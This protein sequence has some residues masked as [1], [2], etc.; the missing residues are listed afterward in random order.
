M[1]RVRARIAFAVATVVVALSGVV[2]V[3]A[4]RGGQ[5]ATDLASPT[6]GESASQTDEVTVYDSHNAALGAF[7]LCAEAAGFEVAADF[8]G[9]GRRPDRFELILPA[10]EPLADAEVREANDRLERCGMIH[11]EPVRE[12]WTEALPRPT[13]AELDEMLTRVNL[14]VSNGGVP[15]LGDVPPFAVPPRDYGPGVRAQVT[16]AANSVELAAFARQCFAA[17]EASSGLQ[18]PIPTWL[19][20]EPPAGIPYS[21]RWLTQCMT[22]GPDEAARRFRVGQE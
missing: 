22:L 12:A 5:Q 14:C 2:A 7:R 19:C 11:L 15:T 6:A 21:S 9:E 16:V 10:S 13:S 18:A 3:S 20:R 1:K 4:L 17:E 8:P